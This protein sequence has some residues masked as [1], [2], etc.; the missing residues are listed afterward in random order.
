MQSVTKKKPFTWEFMENISCF[1]RQLK[2][3][4][5]SIVLLRNVIHGN[6]VAIHTGINAPAGVTTLQLNSSVFPLS[7]H[8]PLFLH[9][10]SARTR[11]MKMSPL[12]PVQNLSATSTHTI[13]GSSCSAQC[14]AHRVPASHCHLPGVSHTPVS[15]TYC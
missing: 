9:T 13:R 6:W 11:L 3:E 7:H 15:N 4:G 5:V 2:K 14:V 10:L 8:H 12:P 1:R